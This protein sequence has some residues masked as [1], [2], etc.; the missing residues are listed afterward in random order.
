M[1]HHVRTVEEVLNSVASSGRVCPQP[2]QWDYLWQLL[3]GRKHS[4]TTWDPPPPLIL[5]AWW[6]SSDA[7]KRERFVHHL[8]Y[9]RDHGA[10]EAV[11]SYLV[12][13]RDDQWHRA[14]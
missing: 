5:G 2:Q 14:T 8:K 12:G 4:G 10:L 1:R 3:P 11:A 13:L 9:A 7:A 6:E